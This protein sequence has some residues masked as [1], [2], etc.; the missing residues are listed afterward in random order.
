MIQKEANW[1]TLEKQV[2]ITITLEG[3]SQYVDLFVVPTG[4]ETY[5]QQQLIEEI[6]TNQNVAEYVWDVPRDTHHHFYVVAYNKDVGRKSDIYN[7][8]SKN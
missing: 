4:S 8:V 3:N 5:K 2:K 1:F 7:V 6:D